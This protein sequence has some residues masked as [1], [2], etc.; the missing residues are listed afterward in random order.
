MIGRGKE[1]ADISAV[2]APAYTRLQSFRGRPFNSW[3]GGREGFWKKIPASACRKKKIACSTNIIESLWQKKGKKYPAHQI[4][5]KKESFRF[6]DEGDYESEFF[7]ILSSAHGRT[8]VILAGKFGRRRQST[9]SFSEKVLV[10]KTSYQMIEISLFSGRERAL[11]L[12]M[13]I[14]V[15]TF[16]VKK[17]YNEALHGVYS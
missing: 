15:S 16:V 11:S 12:S 6:E 17:K 10:V 2:I 7:P 14:S 1:M 4:A 13:E 9:T 8:N 5:R 3:G